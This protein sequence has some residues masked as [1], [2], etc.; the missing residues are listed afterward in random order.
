MSAK[1]RIYRQRGP[2]RRWR[3]RVV[4]ANGRNVGPASQG[5]RDATDAERGF[6]DLQSAV[7]DPRLEIVREDR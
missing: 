3:F 5:F 1:V 4:A 2:R 7:T 6:R